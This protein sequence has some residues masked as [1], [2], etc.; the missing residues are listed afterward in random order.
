[1]KALIVEDD[2]NCVRFIK[3]AIETLCR[4]VNHTDRLAEALKMLNESYDAVWLDLALTDSSA[5]NTIRAIPEIRKASPKATLI[6]VSGYGDSYREQA[7][8]AGAD[9]YAS[10][11]DLENF[12]KDAIAAIF[13]QAAVHAMSRGVDSSRILEKVVGF[14]QDRIYDIRRRSGSVV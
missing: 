14:F 10:K 3:L 4:E 11:V 6:V 1:M 8:R 5:H 13:T 9:V 7:M 12:N 2:P